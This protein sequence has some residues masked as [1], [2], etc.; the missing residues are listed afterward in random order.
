MPAYKIILNFKPFQIDVFTNSGELIISVNSRQLFKF[1][2]F[3][4]KDEEKKAEDGEG[5]WEETFK[6]HTDT[7]PFGSSS[8]G[9]DVSFIGYKHIYG[10]P[11]HSDSFALRSTTFEHVE[12]IKIKNF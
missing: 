6:S 4:Q 12:I 2:H 1:E 10:L 9:L 7:K 3:R 5:F 8:I 11:E